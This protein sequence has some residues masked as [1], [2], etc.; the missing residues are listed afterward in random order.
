MQSDMFRLYQDEYENISFARVCFSSECGYL[1][2][3][4]GRNVCVCVCCGTRLVHYLCGAAK[5]VYI[6]ALQ[7]NDGKC[8]RWHVL[9]RPGHVDEREFSNHSNKRVVRL[10]TYKS[11]VECE[12]CAVSWDRQVWAMRMSRNFTLHFLGS[13]FHIPHATYQ[14]HRIYIL[15]YGVNFYSIYV[16]IIG[17]VPRRSFSVHLVY[18]WEHDWLANARYKFGWRGSVAWRLSE[19]LT[20]V[21]W[22]SGRR[23]WRV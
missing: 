7:S 11:W 22:L 5:K 19:V 12:R 13:V 17:S 10:D 21:D 4:A 3:N 2:K 1:R 23:W 14:C 9:D 18:L 20:K 8:A 16:F 15:A 6:V